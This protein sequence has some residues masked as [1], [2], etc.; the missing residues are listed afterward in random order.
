MMAVRLITNR[1]GSAAV[2]FALVLPILL[3]LMMSCLELGNYFLSEHALEK[4]LR[5]G[6]RYAARQTFDAY[7]T[8]DAQPTDPVYSNTE[9]LVRTGQLSGG[10]DRLPH[11]DQATFSVTT[12]CSAGNGTVTYTGIYSGMTSGARYVVVSASLPYQPVLN[13][14]GFATRSLTLNA[15]EQA[16]VDGI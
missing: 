5:D 10:T 11:W 6:A 8:C 9:Q 12:R 14:Y 4:G 13:L 15:T 1:S 3:L 7:A 16:P 2:E